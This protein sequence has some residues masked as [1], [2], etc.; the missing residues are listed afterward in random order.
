MKS[1]AIWLTCCLL[2]GMA[3]AEETIPV[4][5]DTDIG[6]DIEDTWALAYLLRW[7]DKNALESQI[8]ERLITAP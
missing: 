4:I 6:G 1:A 2:S 5:F 7:R 8:V 3:I